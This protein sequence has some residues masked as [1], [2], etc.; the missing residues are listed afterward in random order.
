MNEPSIAAVDA[1]IDNLVHIVDKLADTV[2]NLNTVHTEIN[3]LSEKVTK[4]ENNFDSINKD[5]RLVSDKVI[6]N[7]IQADEYRY[8]KK[9]FISFMITAFIGGGYMTKTTIDNSSRQASA[10]AEIVSAIKEGSAKI[11]KGK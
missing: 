2:S 4:C 11:N 9:I 1:K 6:T 10:M 5:L 7:S 8:I 3:H